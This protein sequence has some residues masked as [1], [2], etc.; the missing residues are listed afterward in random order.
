MRLSDNST[1]VIPRVYI[2]YSKTMKN[3][4]EDGGDEECEEIPLPTISTEV[5]AKIQE[6]LEYLRANPEPTIN[7]PIITGDIHDFTEQWYADFI[8]FSIDKMDFLF[9]LLTAANFLDIKM[10]LELGC[11]KVATYIKERDVQGIRELFGIE[12]D[13]SPEEEKK[14]IDENEWARNNF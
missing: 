11:A 10:L 1:I 8:D 12:N 6:F 14:I 9:D 13:F 2:E 3:A 7:K 5:F 4:V